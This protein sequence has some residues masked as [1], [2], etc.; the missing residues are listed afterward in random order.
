MKNILYTII[1]SFLFSSS[2]FA[3]EITHYSTNH[4]NSIHNVTVALKNL[5][6]SAEVRCVI[7]KENDKPVGMN[8]GYING[9]GTIRIRIPSSPEK[10]LA[11]CWELE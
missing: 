4:N 6:D 9:V 1:L 10:T 8:D 2:V 3:A 11:H 5:N 7:K